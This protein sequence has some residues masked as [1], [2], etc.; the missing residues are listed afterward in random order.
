MSFAHSV[1]ASSTREKQCWVDVPIEVREQEGAI[2][3]VGYQSFG[4]R[5]NL[6][7]IHLDPSVRYPVQSFLL[8]DV[9]NTV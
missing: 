4:T 8:I 7:E 9:N 6:D 1:R 3:R 5:Y 2:V